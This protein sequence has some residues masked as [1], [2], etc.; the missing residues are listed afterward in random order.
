MSVADTIRAKLTE[1]FRPEAL[2]IED[3]SSRHRGHA[4]AR[5]GGETHFRVR[6]VSRAFEGASRVDRQRRIYDALSEE[7]RGQVHALAL[8]ALTPAEAVVRPTS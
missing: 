4:G 3:E 2:V 1:E 7:L 6:I 8:T 5:P